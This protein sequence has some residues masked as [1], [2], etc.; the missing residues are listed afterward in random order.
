MNPTAFYVKMGSS[1]T[2][3]KQIKATFS[4][5]MEFG[6][7]AYRETPISLMPVI[8]KP[9][10]RVPSNRTRKRFVNSAV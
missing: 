2:V 6:P 1:T 3:L 10:S 7:G 5:K 9:A 4:I 8:Q